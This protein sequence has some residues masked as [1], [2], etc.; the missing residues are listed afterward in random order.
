LMRLRRTSKLTS[1]KGEEKTKEEPEASTSPKAVKEGAEDEAPTSLVVVKDEKDKEKTDEEKS[2]S[3]E[4]PKEEVKEEKEKEKEKEYKVR[5]FMFNIADG[6]FTELHTLWQNEGLI[7][8][9]RCEPVISM[10][11]AASVTYR[12]HT[13]QQHSCR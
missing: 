2:T 10:D 8:I 13:C 4:K 1:R 6:G 12:G 3:A 5:K 9:A 11:A 7:E